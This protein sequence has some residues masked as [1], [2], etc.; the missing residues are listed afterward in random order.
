MAPKLQPTFYLRADGAYGFEVGWLGGFQGFA[1][2]TFRS[3]PSLT[4]KAQGLPGLSNGA[5]DGI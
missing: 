2:W 5:E 1:S 3:H 4:E